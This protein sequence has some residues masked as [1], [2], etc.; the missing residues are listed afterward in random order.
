MALYLEFVTQQWMLSGALLALVSLL[1]FHETRKGAP[2][3]SPQQLTNLVNKQEG[4]VVDLRETAEYRAGHIVDAINIPNAQ[5]TKRLPELEKHKTKPLILVC[6]IGQQSGPTS[7]QLK[8]QGFEQV[9]K[10]SGGIAEWQGSQLPLVKK[11]VKKEGKKELNKE[12]KKGAKKEAK[13]LA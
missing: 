12:A 1:L 4:V 5:F 3:L 7:K 9:Y 2:G 10:L 11:E 6:K 13:K 8:A